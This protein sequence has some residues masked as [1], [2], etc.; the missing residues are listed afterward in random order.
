MSVGVNLKIIMTFLGQIIVWNY[1]QNDS[2]ELPNNA[3]T[4]QTFAHG[5][6]KGY[7]GRKSIQ[8][9]TSRYSHQFTPQ[10]WQDLGESV[11]IFKWWVLSKIAIE[12]YN[13][14]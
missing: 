10:F 3:A 4:R 6:F 1:L 2:P 8:E 12:S 13:E 11:V 7:S 14:R 9:E 5:A